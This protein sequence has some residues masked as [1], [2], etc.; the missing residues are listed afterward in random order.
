MFDRIQWDTNFLWEISKVR[1]RRFICHIK[2]EGKPHK[3]VRI[4][5]LSFYFMHSRVIRYERSENVVRELK[6]D[7]PWQC[8]LMNNIFTIFNW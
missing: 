7:E 3:T 2:S 5:K 1:L 8:H 4:P 6:N